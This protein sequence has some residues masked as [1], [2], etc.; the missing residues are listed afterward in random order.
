MTDINEL[1][2]QLGCTSRTLRFYE[3]KGL[4]ESTKDTH[5]NRR[6]YTK[7]QITNIKNVLI[8]RS[9]GLPVSKIREYLSNDIPLEYII[10]ERKAELIASMAALNREYSLL[11][12]ALSV[13]ENGEDIF[14]EN[15]G[16]ILLTDKK[17]IAAV[18]TDLFIS[19]DYRKCFDYFSPLL[20]EYLPLS[21][22]IKVTT[23]TLGLSGNIISKE[24]IIHY[25]KNANCF[26]SYIKCEKHDLCIKL[27][28][29]SDKVQGI[30]LTL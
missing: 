9:L 8:L 2:K 25:D 5:S 20:K 13:I 3:E 24:A 23:D 1:C 10:K 27:V 19:S 7:E 18:F 29:F 12:E 6:K 21:A 14:T 30:W 15:N 26:Y 28:L 17:H 22:F 11:C 16:N 4:V